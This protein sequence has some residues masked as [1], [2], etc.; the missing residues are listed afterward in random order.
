MEAEN[1]IFDDSGQG[2]VVKQV[3]QV[4]P[5]V[6]V[7]VLAKTLV[8]EA[9]HLGNLSAFVVSSENCDSVLKAHLQAHEQR[10]S[11][12]RVVSSV[13][14]IAHEEVVGV[15]RSTTNLK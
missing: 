7:A 1:L 2:Q 13:N 11:L 3:S 8:V 15:G 9:I 5:D 10:D 6:S 12:Y 4:L 14:I